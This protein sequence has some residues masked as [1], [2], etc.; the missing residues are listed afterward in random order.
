MIF[1]NLEANDISLIKELF[2]EE[3]VYSDTA[4]QI[5]NKI[6]YIKNSNSAQSVFYYV[7]GHLDGKTLY[8]K[9]AKINLGY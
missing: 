4:V 2:M 1:I 7:S 6:G 8:L 9:N 3:E 5:D